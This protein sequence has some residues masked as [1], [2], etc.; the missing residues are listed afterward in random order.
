MAIDTVLPGFEDLDEQTVYKRCFDAIRNSNTKNFMVEFDSVNAYAA[1]D[2][3]E[4]SLHQALRI[5]VS[6]RC[7]ILVQIE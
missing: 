4:S 7:A 6:G 2:I 1:L 5:E 3:D